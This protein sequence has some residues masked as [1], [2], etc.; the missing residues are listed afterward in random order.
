MA[1]QENNQLLPSPRS[2]RAAGIAAA[3]AVA[4]ELAIAAQVFMGSPAQSGETPWQVASRSRANTVRANC[5]TQ[6]SWGVH[7]GWQRI[8]GPWRNILR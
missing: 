8:P 2:A 3:I 4:I 1:Y 7:T 5:R 6:G